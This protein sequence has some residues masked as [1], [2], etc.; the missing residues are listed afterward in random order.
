MR[1]MFWDA[2]YSDINNAI[3]IPRY[4]IDDDYR[5][6]MKGAEYG[7]IFTSTI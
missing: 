3:S 7:T 2:V 6:K 4:F 1:K 5:D